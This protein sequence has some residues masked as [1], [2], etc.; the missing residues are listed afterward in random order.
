VVIAAGGAAKI[1]ATRSGDF[2]VEL[3]IKKATD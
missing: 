2:Y 3:E 1:Y